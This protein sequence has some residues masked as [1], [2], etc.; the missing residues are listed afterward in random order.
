MY[1]EIIFGAAS[2]KYRYIGI[3]HVPA[4]MK[5]LLN[6]IVLH[7]L[8]KPKKKYSKMFAKFANL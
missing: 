6:D 1:E 5:F 7:T 8:Y 2:G 3:Q 4:N